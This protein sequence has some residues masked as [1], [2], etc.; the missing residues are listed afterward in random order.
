MWHASAKRLLVA[1]D[2]RPAGAAPALRYAVI[3]G[4]RV[5]ESGTTIDD[6]WARFRGQPVA[7]SFFSTRSHLERQ[8]FPAADRKVQH[9]RARRYIENESFFTDPFQLRLRAASLHGRDRTVDLV[10]VAQ[11]D[12][13]AAVAAM[14]RRFALAQL[15][16]MESAVAALIARVTRQRVLVLWSRGAVVLALVVEAGA[17]LTRRLDYLGTL[18]DAGDDGRLALEHAEML[19]A[20][21]GAS[22]QPA[23]YTTVVLGELRRGLTAARPGSALLP[24]DAARS[25]YDGLERLFNGA[26]REAALD[27]PELYGLAYVGTD[28]NFIAPAEVA[29]ERVR[30]AA[31]PAALAA[32]LTGTVLAAAGF[33]HGR[34]AAVLEQ[35]YALR[36]DRLQRSQMELRPRLPEDSAA[37]EGVVAL[38]QRRSEALRLQPFLAWLSGEIPPGMTITALQIKPHTETIRPGGRTAS[39][40]LPGRFVAT[41]EVEARGGYAEAQRLTVELVQ[42]LGRRIELRDAS[43]HSADAN[44]AAVLN[45]TLL[46][47]AARF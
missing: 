38:L 12:L 21:L 43:L 31:A 29:R 37:L 47:E 24:N 32:A 44:R 1:L 22:T 27:H 23:Q 13:N 8:V 19:A 33:Q 46:I 45:A 26:T 5:L 17:V 11:A 30:R 7:A 4:T 35:D 16:T 36:S 10:A 40:H 28:F 42:R 39:R 25:L 15:V 18:A 34:Q 41:L 3:Q 9:L 6:R 20:H 2:P 14:P